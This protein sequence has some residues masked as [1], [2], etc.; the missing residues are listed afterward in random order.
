MVLIILSLK[1]YN[2]GL[3]NTLMTSSGNGKLRVAMISF[4]N[5][6]KKHP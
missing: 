1:P 3:L 2:V 6:E 5:W 4:D